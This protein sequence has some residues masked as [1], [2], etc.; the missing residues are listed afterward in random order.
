MKHINNIYPHKTFRQTNICAGCGSGVSVT[1]I[2]RA[3]SPITQHQGGGPNKKIAEHEMEEQQIHNYSAQLDLK[4][5]YKAYKEIYDLNIEHINSNGGESLTNK[6]KNILIA[7]Y[8]GNMHET[9]SKISS[10][11]CQLSKSGYEASVYIDGI[12]EYQR[13]VN[14]ELIKD[15]ILM[16]LNAD[17][18]T[19][20]KID[21]IKEYVEGLGGMNNKWQDLTEQ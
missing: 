16:F 6:E 9:L 14:Q 5:N 7:G 4:N 17:V 3:G 8:L 21:L 15:D 13:I 11:L 1:D 2:D 10:N 18:S 20:E 12:R 19:S